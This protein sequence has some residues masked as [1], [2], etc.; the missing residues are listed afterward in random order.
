VWGKYVGYFLASSS[1]VPGRT[2]LV[3]YQ[4]PNVEVQKMK[5]VHAPD[6][7]E[8]VIPS[9]SKD[10]PSLKKYPRFLEF[11]T[12]RVYD[13]GEARQPGQTWLGSDAAAFTVMLKE[14]S[15]C[16]CVRLRAADL[17]SLFQAIELFLKMDAPPWEVDEWA[18]AKRPKMKK[19]KGS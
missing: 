8:R 18:M 7:G 6:T 14:P 1:T 15:A 11:M 5:R 2:P 3:K 4:W 12:D 17:E 19:K 16:L 13:D 9:L 10:C